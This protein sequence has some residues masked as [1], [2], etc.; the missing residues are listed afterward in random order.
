M[1]R[2]QSL[3]ITGTDT[4][5]GKTTAACALARGWVNA[6]ERVGAMK[7]VAAGLVNGVSEDLLA[8]EAAC[9]I[10]FDRAL[11]CQYALTEP[12][13]PHLAAARAGVEIQAAAIARSY[14]TLVETAPQVMVV[15][16]SKVGGGA[17]PHPSPL[18]G[19]EGAIA[20]ARREA[21]VSDGAAGGEDLI[22]AGPTHILI[23]GAGGALVPLNDSEDMLDIARACG[24]PVLFVVGMKLG[25]INHARLTEAAIVARGLFCV[26]WVANV[27][28]PNMPFLH[29]NLET[30]KTRLSTP[31]Q[32]VCGW[33]KPLLS[34]TLVEK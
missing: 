33:K 9:N 4:E 5:I 6:G 19:G 23:E 18:P 7:P 8:L 10:H 29:E 21:E 1:L 15:N 20:G 28:D 14:R 16:R 34:A 26:G 3:F 24:L 13:A 32:G 11:A 27:L 22:V 12:I 31:F 2:P 17:F 25:C 30:L